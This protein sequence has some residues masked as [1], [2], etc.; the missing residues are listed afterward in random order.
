LD[1]QTSFDY[2]GVARI[3]VNTKDGPWR[4]VDIVYCWR[5]KDD[6]LTVIATSEDALYKESN[7]FFSEKSPFVFPPTLTISGFSDFD[8]DKQLEII[9]SLSRP[10]AIAYST[11]GAPVTTPISMRQNTLFAWEKSSSGPLTW[12][13][14]FQTVEHEAR[15]VFENP[16]K[17][18]IEY[19][20]R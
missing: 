18:K 1:N 13:S 7:L 19:P 9:T 11:E 5:K 17:V 6:S 12:K 16:A 10:L 20:G 8:K 3:G 14:V 15:I 4:W 2:A